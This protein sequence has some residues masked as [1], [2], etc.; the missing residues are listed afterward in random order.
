MKKVF[1]LLLLALFVFTVS[2][3]GDK[4]PVDDR[5]VI[6]YAA[7]NLGLEEDNNI[8]RRMIDAFMEK[9]PDIRVDVIER[10]RIVNDDGLEEDATWDQFFLYTSSNWQNA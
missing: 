1:T 9:Y 10:P 3:C 6:T 4:T 2:A 7:W 8:E 5:T